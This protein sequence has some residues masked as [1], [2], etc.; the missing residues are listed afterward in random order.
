MNGPRSPFAVDLRKELLS[1]VAPVEPGDALPDHRAVLEDASTELGL[2]LTFRIDG[3]RAHVEIAPA[4]DGTPHAARSA[5][6][7]FSYRSD[8]ERLEPLEGQAL[9]RAVARLVETNEDA[10]LARI[11][12]AAELHDEPR[13][14]MV[15]VERILEPAGTQDDPF[16]TLSPYV[17]CLIGCRFCYA[18]SRLA[19]MRRLLGLSRA[20]WGSWVDARVNASRVLARELE[21]VAR[22]PIKFC[23]IVADPYHPLERRLRLTRSCLEVL[24]AARYPNV[25]LL[26][27]SA[28][29][30]DDLDLLAALPG[31]HVGFSIPT[32]DDA[33]R[34]HFEPRAAPIEERL[35]IL[36]RM[37]R[38]AIETMAVV[39]P[40]LP[41]PVDALADAL[42]S[43]VGSVSLDVLGGVE[44]AHEEFADPRWPQAADPR[45]QRARA[46]AL[47][48]ALQRR[49]V[50]IWTGELP[51]GL[52]RGGAR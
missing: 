18:Q 40:M 25:M 39:Q 14:R 44:G 1:L 41:G 48:D 46:D 32:I 13:V 51:P 10:V 20:A 5:R 21:T 38:A 2:R 7:L 6:L 50:P 36:G 11:E 42:A 3:G 4:D 47:A 23:P 33:V 12:R 52:H 15:E 34:R 16:H 26:T 45:W 43:T 9:C 28:S 49:G 24:A 30:E 22:H 27:R 8:G 17:G 19:P 37:R 29:I 31:V 35:R